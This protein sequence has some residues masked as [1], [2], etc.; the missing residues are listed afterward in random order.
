MARKR[1]GRGEGSIFEREDGQWV[2]SISLG[3][4]GQGR[5]R[6]PTVY[7]DT[8]AEV[9]EKLRAL[10]NETG[11]LPAEVKQLTVGQYLKAWLEEIKA[12]R[13]HTTHDRYSLLVDRQ[14]IPHIGTMKLVKV[15]TLHVEQ[16]FTD[17][18][19]AGESDWTVHHVAVVLGTAM[20]TAVRKGLLLVNPLS[21]VTKPR[22]PKSETTFWDQAQARTFLAAAEGDRLFAL[23]P[24][25]FTTGMREGE[26][27]GLQWPDIDFAQGFLTV[28]RLLEEVRGKFALRDPK[29]DPSRRRIDLPH[30]AL[31]ALA[32]HRKAMLAEGQDM[33]GLVFC[34]TD[35]GPLRRSNVARRSFFKIIAR[36]GLP[37]I[38]FHDLRHSAASLLLAAGEN[39][40]VV[41][42][43][44]GHSR[45]E[46]TLNIYSHVV[47]TMQQEA[48]RKLDRLLG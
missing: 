2:G 48:A 18:R 39:P 29:T 47:P 43:R 8:K 21:M 27:F 32:D 12:S 13:K 25:A 20:K 14:M 42:E 44:L 22:L 11:H 37:K 5:R 33:Q 17:L 38:R 1:R 24:L 30:L 26:M 35:G 19:Q 45:I 3:Y 4:D 16:F 15:S 23:Y 7:G 31:Q 41:Q 6:R 46:T 36:A 34:D 40:K 10:Q 9:I 28:R